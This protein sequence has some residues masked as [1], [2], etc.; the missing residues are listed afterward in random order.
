MARE[1]KRQSLAFTG[2]MAPEK[3][4]KMQKKVIDGVTI[5]NTG[6]FLSHHGNKEWL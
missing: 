3:S 4:V 1:L 2:R 5:E 6:S